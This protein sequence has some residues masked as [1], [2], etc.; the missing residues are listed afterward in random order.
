M[1]AK[2]HLNQNLNEFGLHSNRPEAN[3]F[4]TASATHQYILKS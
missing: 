3:C 4:L 2:L 1:Q